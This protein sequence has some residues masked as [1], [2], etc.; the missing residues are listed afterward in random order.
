MR[1]KI[2]SPITKKLHVF[3]ADDDNADVRFFKIALGQIAEKVKITL[4]RDVRELL[5]FLKLVKPDIIVL[6]MN[7]PYNK[8]I[9]CLTEVR[10]QVKLNEVPVLVYSDENIKNQ[11]YKTYILGANL[12]I[13]KPRSFHA[14]SKDL[15]QQLSERMA[16]L[17]PQPY[18]DNYVLNLTE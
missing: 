8:G 17:V 12:Y 9:E 10:S 1:K 3:I 15:L 7:M 2:T 13:A 14:L 11:V 16:K 18:I 4:A 5:E 6:N